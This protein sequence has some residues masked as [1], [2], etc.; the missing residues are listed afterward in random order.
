[1]GTDGRHE[2][3]GNLVTEVAAPTTQSPRSCVSDVLMTSKRTASARMAA[4]GRSGNPFCASDQASSTQRE[5]ALKEICRQLADFPLHTLT[6][7]AG[8][9]VAQ[10][11]ECLLALIG[12]RRDERVVRHRCR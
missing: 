2:T 10:A 3:A 7:E 5:A 12:T 6:I 11:R 8:C 9:V 1:M 4:I